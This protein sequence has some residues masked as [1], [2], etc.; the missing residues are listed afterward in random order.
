MIFIIARIRFFS[1]ISLQLIDIVKVFKLEKTVSRFVC[2]TLKLGSC[3]TNL[4]KT[5]LATTANTHQTQNFYFTRSIFRLS[6]DICLAGY[7]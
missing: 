2:I 5:Y 3:V 4:P 1:T 6:I 7:F